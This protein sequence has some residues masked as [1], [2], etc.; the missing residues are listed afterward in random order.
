MEEFGSLQGGTI[1]LQRCSKLQCWNLGCKFAQCFCEESCK[2]R[3]LPF[4]GQMDSA[5]NSSITV[6]TN[7]YDTITEILPRTGLVYSEQAALAESLCKPKI[8]PI[9]SATLEK[10]EKL[11]KEAKT[12]EEN[13]SHT[14]T[15]QMSRNW[16]QTKKTLFSWDIYLLKIMRITNKVFPTCWISWWMNQ[17]TE[18]KLVCVFKHSR[19]TDITSASNFSLSKKC[20]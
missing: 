19:T 5:A 4:A 16:K 9:K 3:P 15:F 1:P 2:N 17:H 12:A 18:N 10:L 13:A 11:E 6:N 20:L 8:I 7:N 14:W